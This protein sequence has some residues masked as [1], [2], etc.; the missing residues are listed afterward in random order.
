MS[1]PET[2]GGPP[3]WLCL[4]LPL[5]L[6]LGVFGARVLFP[7]EA[8]ERW[9]MGELGIIE[10]GTVVLLL[11]AIAMSIAAL[12]RSTGLT[13]WWLLAMTLACVY[14]AGEEISWG[15]HLVGWDTPPTLRELNDQDETNLHNM[16]SWLDQKPRLLLELWVLALGIT[17]LAP[18]LRAASG[19]LAFLWGDARLAVPALAT[20]LVRLPERLYSWMGEVPTFPFDFRLAELQELMFAQVLLLYLWYRWRHPF[21]RLELPPGGDR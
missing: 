9:M 21:E 6:S 10:L 13:R 1:K 17:A 19:R 7:P 2:D 16:S 5:A 11:P 4:L 20:I 8:F 14:F 3:W 12:R 15:Q 18:R